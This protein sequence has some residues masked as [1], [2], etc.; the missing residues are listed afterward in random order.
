MTRYSSFLAYHA[1]LRVETR[2]ARP[3]I[4]RSLS[5]LRPTLRIYFGL[6]VL[7]TAFARSQ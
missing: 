3:S 2:R 6:F 4:S 1:A 5:A 7:E